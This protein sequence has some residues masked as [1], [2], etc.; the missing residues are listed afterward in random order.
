MDETILLEVK[1]IEKSFSGTKV[2]HGVNFQLRKGEI[3]ALVGENGAGKSTLMNIIDGVFAP[4]CGEIFINGKREV[5]HNPNEAMELGIGF[6]HQEIALCP[7]V[8]V[9]ENIFMPSINRSKKLSVDYKKLYKDAQEILKLMGSIQPESC[10]GELNISKQQIVEIAKA[11]SMNCKVLILDEPTGAL[12]ETESEALFQI[13][14]ELKK[15]GIGIIYISHRMAEIF[16]QCDRVSVLR[17]GYLIGTYKIADMNAED[18]VNKMVGREIGAIYPPK[19]KQQTKEVLLEVKGY[20]DGKYF[21]NISFQL[22]AGEILGLAGLI[23]AGRSELAQAVCGL[24]PKI[25]G[26]VFYHGRKIAIN[27][28]RNSI[29]QG[30]V[31]LT[32]DR[33]IQ[34]LFLD[35]SIEQNITAMAVENVSKH[36][37]IER[38]LESAQG[39]NYIQLLNIKANHEQQ[40]LSSLSG[41]NQQKVLISKLL[42]VKPKIIFMD[43]PTRGIDVG[44]K[45]EIHKLL[46]KLVEEGIGIILISS[47]L[48][49]VVGMCDR[50]L[51]MHEGNLSGEVTAGHINET[52]IIRL[53]SGICH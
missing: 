20:S 36:G 37:F 49:E 39:R 11:L 30:I 24:R 3:H 2:L 13:M 8:T 18:V 29:K 7:D 12:T 45:A 26:E 22:Y 16:G 53:A 9:A 33:K 27:N 52:E 19:N 15:N 34:G 25:A 44:A 1:G 28:S 14:R 17:D 23:G 46:R 10:V 21:Q 47:E 38:G 32:E 31:Y 5:I 48:P 40:I 50:V 42:T 4:D 51:V 41:G 35:M 43:E 6:V